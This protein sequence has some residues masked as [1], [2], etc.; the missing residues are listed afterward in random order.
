MPPAALIRSAQISQPSSPGLPQAAT[1]PV[2]GARKPILIN[3]SCALAMRG[4]LVAAAA[5]AV[6]CRNVR[7]V[8]PGLPNLENIVVSPMLAR[9]DIMVRAGFL[10]AN[11]L[12]GMT[13]GAAGLA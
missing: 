5:A 11:I 3:L 10:E 4:R 13:R 2:R 1:A 9:P 8:S 7:R 12:V 6:D